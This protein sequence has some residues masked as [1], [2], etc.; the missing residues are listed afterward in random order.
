MLVSS[1]CWAQVSNV[2]SK[3]KVINGEAFYVHSVLGGQTLETIANAYFTEVSLIEKHNPGLLE[4][5]SSGAQLKVPYSDES[6]EAMSKRA[7]YVVPKKAPTYIKKDISKA[8]RDKDSNQLDKPFVMPI[9]RPRERPTPMEEAADLLT[10]PDDNFDKL[11]EKNIGQEDEINE[12]EPATQDDSEKALA[13]LETLSQSINESLE[14]LAQIQE[15]LQ[16][17]NVDPETGELIV[18]KGEKLPENIILAS[19]FLENQI[20]NYFDTTAA[21][22]FSL[23]EYF[24][25]DINSDA[26]IR[27][28]KDERT[29]TNENSYFLTPYD[30]RGLRVDSL[31]KS[32]QILSIGFI[33]EIGRYKYKVDIKKNT[34]KLEQTEGFR[35]QFLESNNHEEMILEAANNAG[36]KGSGEFIIMDGYREVASFRAFEYNPFGTKDRVIMHQKVVRIEQ[37][38]F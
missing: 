11:V 10:L 17:T 3:I 9:P 13:D 15:A 30:L 38:N 27:K 19:T 5:L 4:P 25:V 1:V 35:S 32:R 28:V 24:I 36:L 37:M 26:R 18:P 16:S 33:S 31:E 7:K 8:E 22:E 34:V 14:S 12:P 29:V 23:K 6:L 2:N 20:T 21:N